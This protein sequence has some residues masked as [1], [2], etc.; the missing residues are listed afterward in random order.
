[1]QAVLIDL[2]RCQ[3]FGQEEQW[4]AS[5]EEEE[6]LEAFE[7]ARSSTQSAGSVLGMAAAPEGGSR[8]P[9]VQ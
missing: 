3:R 9:S 4:K 5:R 7:E 8:G 1:M 2:G 6:L